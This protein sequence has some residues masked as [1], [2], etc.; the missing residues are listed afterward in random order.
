M[1]KNVFVRV[2]NGV[3]GQMTR[4][5][6]LCLTGIL[7]GIEM[8]VPQSASAAYNVGV[9]EFNEVNKAIGQYIAKVSDLSYII[10]GIVGL[11]GALI[12]FWKFSNDEQD[13]RKSIMYLIGGCVGFVALMKFVVMVFGLDSMATGEINAAD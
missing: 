1:K 6:Y 13:L 4:L 8:L 12:I 7:M 5:Q 10:A 3:R 2:W 11:I 9:G